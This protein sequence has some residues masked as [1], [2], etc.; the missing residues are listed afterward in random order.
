MDNLTKKQGIVMLRFGF[1]IVLFFTQLTFAQT[2]SFIVLPGKLHK[3]GT[4]KATASSFDQTKDQ[5]E[6]VLNYKIVA[7][8]LVPV[9]PKHL[10]GSYTQILPLSFL[11][12]RGFLE[13][14]IKK[15]MNIKDAIIK[16]LGRVDIKPYK[17]AH[18]IGIYPTNGKSKIFL[19]FHPLIQGLGWQ[20]LVLI[21]HLNVPFLSNYELKGNLK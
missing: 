21:L 5:F 18:S 3:D 20:N 6:V 4:L 9:D 8:S 17:D 1:L 12:E 7:R 11:D 10:T 13:L 16:H 14:E 15:T 19:S 2:S